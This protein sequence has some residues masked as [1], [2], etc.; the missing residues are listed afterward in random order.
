MLYLYYYTIFFKFQLIF[1]RAFILKFKFKYNFL[2][3]IF[4]LISTF[5]NLN[6]NLI[7]LLKS[8][9]LFCIFI[10][11]FDFGYVFTYGNPGPPYYGPPKIA[12]CTLHYLN[13]AKHA[14]DRGIRGIFS[15]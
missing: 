10:K 6:R 15:F 3:K 1:Y 7:F 9:Y 14:T 12:S 8:F 2:F 11:Y 13:L 5:S 4:K